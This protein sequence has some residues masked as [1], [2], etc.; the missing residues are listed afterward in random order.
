ML[1]KKSESCISNTVSY[2]FPDRLKQAQVTPLYKKNDP[3]E[4]TNYRPVSVLP[5]FSILYEKVLEIQLSDFFD[6]MFDPYLCAFRRDNFSYAGVL[7]LFHVGLFHTVAP[8]CNS[9]HNDVAS[10]ETYS[11]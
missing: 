5:L 1:S 11:S 3:L 2:N 8:L 4:K 9:L 7:R 10:M 6:K